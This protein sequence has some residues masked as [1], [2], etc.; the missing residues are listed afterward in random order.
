MRDPLDPIVLQPARHPAFTQRNPNRA[1]SL[2]GTLCLSN[3]AAFHRADARGY[4]FW[5]EQVMEIDAINPH[6]AGRL[7]RAMDRWAML[8]EPYR[9]GA[10]EAVASVAAKADLSGNVREII[11]RALACAR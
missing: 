11:D 5:A 2:L 1:R 3:P 8:A 4:A 10:R 7:A 6:I 9:S